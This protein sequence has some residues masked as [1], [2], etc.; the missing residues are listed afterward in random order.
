MGGGS[1]WPPLK[2]EDVCPRAYRDGIHGCNQLCPLPAC[3][4][5]AMSVLMLL[6]K[7]ELSIV[8]RL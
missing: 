1:L 7:A 5:I 8:P 3:A 4:S 6:G 2:L